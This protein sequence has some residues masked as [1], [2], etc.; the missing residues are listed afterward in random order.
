MAEV[1]FSGTAPECW[2]VLANKP[3]NPTPEM[4]AALCGE[5]PGGAGYQQR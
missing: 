2:N 3:V 1:D 4:R 5:Y